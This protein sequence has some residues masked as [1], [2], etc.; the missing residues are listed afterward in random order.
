MRRNRMLKEGATYHVTSKINWEKHIYNPDEIKELFLEIIKKAKKK[1]KF[2]I[3]NFVIMGNHYHLLI[4]PGKGENLSRI[5]QWILSV[6]AMIYNKMHKLKGHLFGSRFWSKIVET[7]RQ[8]IDTFNYISYNPV[9][10]MLSD[11]A[12]NYKYGGLYHIK[13]GKFD[14]VDK[15]DFDLF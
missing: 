7:Y 4:T 12:E 14:I 8:F 1:Y 2:S 15:P 13:H 6:F 11:T 3:K 10:A 5:M 9:N